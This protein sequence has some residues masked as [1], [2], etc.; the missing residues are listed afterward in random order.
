MTR[1]ALRASEACL[2]GSDATQLAQSLLLLYRIHHALTSPRLQSS[3]NILAARLISPA[4]LY[5]SALPVFLLRKIVPSPNSA[6]CSLSHSASQV[7]CA[8]FIPATLAIPEKY[9]LTDTTITHRTPTIERH[10][11][12]PS[13]NNNVQSLFDALLI[14]SGEEPGQEGRPH[15]QTWRRRC[16]LL[17]RVQQGLGA[18]TREIT[19]VP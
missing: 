8:G 4:P 5:V 2:K 10:L 6:L 11:Q 17:L 13:E 15:D 16:Q 7:P 1:A 3:P 14:Y 19:A 18:N 9:E 12:C